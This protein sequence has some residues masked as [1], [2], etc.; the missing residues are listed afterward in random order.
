MKGDFFSYNCVVLWFLVT[1][2]HWYT[3]VVGFSLLVYPSPQF[4]CPMANRYPPITYYWTG[5]LILDHSYLVG[6]LINSKIT[7]TKALEP[8]KS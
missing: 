1:D 5:L 2:H 8:L 7:E 3:R 6:N 4:F